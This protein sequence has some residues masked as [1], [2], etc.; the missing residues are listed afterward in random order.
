MALQIAQRWS[1]THAGKEV[2]V[3]PGLIVLHLGVPYIKVFST[4]A[5]SPLLYPNEKIPKNFSIRNSSV[6]KRLYQERDEKSGLTAGDSKLDAL[7]DQG[8]NDVSAKKARKRRRLSMDPFHMSSD[9]IQ[10]LAATSKKDVLAI[11]LETKDLKILIDALQEHEASDQLLDG[12]QSRAYIKSGKY[13]K[14]REQSE[15][16]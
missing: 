9:G 5:L 12:G 15:S 2:V 16:D 13:A 3:P 10:M 6:I 8:G 11:K 4:S 14:G 1:I 7:F